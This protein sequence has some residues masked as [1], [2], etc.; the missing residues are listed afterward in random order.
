MHQL[1]PVRRIVNVDVWNE[2]GIRV[3]NSLVENGSGFFNQ[4]AAVPSLHAAYPLLFL[5]FFWAGARWYWRVLL[6]V[7]PLAMCFTLVY[8]GEHYVSD[9]LLGWVYA[10]MAFTLVK[11]W[12][13]WRAARRAERSPAEPAGARATAPAPL[14][15]AVERE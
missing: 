2:L 8:A 7:Y 10:V 14:T 5:L 3:A 13:R 9:I 11:A 6:A 1:E 15:A 4:V 12:E